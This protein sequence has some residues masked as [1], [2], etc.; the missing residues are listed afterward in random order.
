MQ[1]RDEFY[2]CVEKE[3]V[4]FT[5]GAV[6]E[7][8]TNLRRAYE[9]TCRPSWVHHFDLT[10]DKQL[11]LVQTLRANINES[12]AVATGGLAGQAQE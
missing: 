7:R 5:V 4:T 3:S 9:Q 8:C 6:P 1:A 10:H 12:A 2:Q 11:R